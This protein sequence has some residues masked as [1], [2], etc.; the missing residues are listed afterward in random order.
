MSTSSLI[1]QWGGAVRN[2]RKRRHLHAKKRG[3]DERRTHT[4]AESRD[5]S[6]ERDQLRAADCE[7]PWL[8]SQLHF[9]CELEAPLCSWIKANPALCALKDPP[10][11]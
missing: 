1:A 7:G 5:M 6:R 2:E 10:G 11:V 4:E 3:I 9:D 8:Y